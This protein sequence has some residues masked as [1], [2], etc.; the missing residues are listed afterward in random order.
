VPAAVY[1]CVG[2]PV[3][4]VEPSPKNH[5]NVVPPIVL[6][7]NDT[8]AGREQLTVEGEEKCTTGIESTFTYADF[9]L[10]PMHPTPSESIN[11][12]G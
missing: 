9:T 8:D 7:V 4:D 11:V 10:E 6:F 2:D 12:T 5:L 1:V 3:V